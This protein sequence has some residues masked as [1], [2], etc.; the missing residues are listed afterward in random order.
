MTKPAARNILLNGCFRSGTTL[1]DKLMHNHADIFMASQAYPSLFSYT[2]LQFLNDLGIERRYPLGHLFRE[3]SYSNDDFIS[4]L[5]D[6]VLEDKDIDQVLSLLTDAGS[7]VQTSGMDRYR[8]AINPGT[9][10]DVYQQMNAVLPRLFPD[11]GA[12]T[13]LGS[14]EVFCEEYIP[15]LLKH[16][17]KVVIIVRDPRDVVS[18]V[19][20]ADAGHMGMHRPLLF[21]L[22]AW[23]KNVAFLLGYESHAN[24]C[25]VRFEDLVRAPDEE[26]A[27]LTDFLEL[28]VYPEDAFSDGIYDQQG[29]L[30]KSNSSFSEAIGFDTTSVGRYTEQLS[31]EI[32]A[33]INAMC[34]PEMRA[35]GYADK[36]AFDKSAL[37]SCREPYEV[38]HPAFKNDREYSE[39]PRRLE[40]ETRRY[41]MLMDETVELTPAELRSWYILPGA[42]TRLRESVRD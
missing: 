41:A 3:E 7:F 16:G 12:L 33:Y 4:F 32:I 26:L 6:Y 18:S 22:R 25:V 10:H 35:L 1:L 24:L 11:S 27:R 5:D 2:K 29:K 40:D 8:D 28:P 14:K 34:G 39:D 42:Y 37:D 36:S 19:Y 17:T 9:F 31:D 20:R 23:R 21:T 30:W 15:Y 38:L 13:Y